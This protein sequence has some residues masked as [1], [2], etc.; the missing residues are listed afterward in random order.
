MELVADV[1]CY[2]CGHVSGELIGARTLP[3]KEW[4]FEPRQGEPRP[5]GKL[6]CLRCGGPIYLEDMRAYDA[7][8]P[9]RALRRRLARLPG[10]A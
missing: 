8:D 10:A 7:L 9:V 1:K 5:A 6:R 4:T 3:L 2:H